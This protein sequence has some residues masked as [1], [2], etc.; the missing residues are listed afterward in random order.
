L[1]DTH[2]A[3]QEYPPSTAAPIVEEPRFSVTA[4][5]DGAVLAVLS[6]NFVVLNLRLSAGANWALGRALHEAAQAQYVFE[7]R[8]LQQ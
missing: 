3:E 1:S 7:Q 6:G 4:N 5:P 2:I 8:M